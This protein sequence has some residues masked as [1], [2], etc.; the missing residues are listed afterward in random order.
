[1]QIFRIMNNPEITIRKIR[2]RS[3]INDSLFLDTYSKLMLGDKDISE[4]NKKSILKTAIFFLN[5]KDLNVE[6]LGYRIILRYSILFKDYR[7]IYDI[8]LSRDYIPITKLIERNSDI[9]FDLSSFSKLYI[10][11]YQDLFKIE[12]DGEFIYRSAGQIILNNYSYTKD[13]IAII[14]PTSYGKS[15]MIF[16]KINSN[17]NKKI[18]IIVPSKALL[19]QTKKALLKK[20]YIKDNFKKIITHPDMYKSG[21]DN[22]LAVLTQ[23][24]LLR[25]LQKNE[26]LV[27][28]LLLVDEA[29]N[30][31][32][33]DERAHLLAQVILILKKR[34]EELLINFYTPFL[35]D[36]KNLNIINSG[37]DL[38]S[39]P[40][41]EY[42]K[43]EKFYYYNFDNSDY[44]LYDQFLNQTFKIKS[45]TNYEKDISFVFS[46]S[47]I[48]NIV[49]L[50]RPKSVERFSLDATKMM[51]DIDL[52]PE[53]EKIIK[54]ISDFI[55][56]D[57]N[58]ITCLR[59]GILYHHGGIPDIVRLYIEDIYTK[60]DTFKFIVTTSTLLEGVNIPA[61][62]I[63]ILTP[64]KGHGHLTSSQFK[65]LI[66]RACRFREVFDPDN[67]KLEM[68]EPQ[69]FLLNG[70]YSPKDFNPIS[71]YEKKVNC[72]INIKDKVEN[73][74]LENS[75]NKETLTEKLEYLE[76]MESGS[77]GLN[78]FRSPYSDIGKYCYSNNINDFDI[79]SN[80]E[81]LVSNLKDYNEV[82]L[83]P[84]DNSD[85]LINAIVKIFF[86]NVELK[87]KRDNIKRL[88]NNEEARKFYSMFVGWRSKGTPYSVMINNFL[89]Y[90]ESRLLQGDTLIYLGPKW[91]EEKRNGY[92]DL[93]VNMRSKNKVQRINL[94]IAKIKEE[95]EFI[96]FNILKYLEV[97]KDLDLVNSDFYD[98][99]KYGTKN[100][101]VICML[102]NGLSMEL[103][104]LLKEKYLDFL[105]IDLDNDI[106]SYKLGLVKS[107]K[108]NNENGVLIFEAES[109]M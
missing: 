49:Y 36:S 75:T 74:L 92:Q 44:G 77:S 88:K 53:I 107:M 57:Y 59:S 103:A 63:F 70:S 12:G 56:P 61:E 46:N 50:N 21:Q 65:N 62:K 11:S 104:K 10:N 102:K 95:Q 26:S 2:H 78:D 87:D 86:S 22:L 82:V 41:S 67:G 79:I 84:I 96:D 25:L 28:D 94:A 100:K 27:I 31:L 24:R 76:N 23:E 17:L 37:I 32:D 6:K 69:I 39:Y 83:E 48:K 98:Q 108:D 13:N 106:I 85:L 43:I 5:S 4:S 55:H 16:K 1:M 73:P 47:S 60:Y 18:C 30:L 68:L 99:V 64:Q 101:I 9:S 7:P 81:Q 91:G 54:S 35:S 15:E 90:W 14:A 105:E 38:N 93:Y 71:F 20:D 8:A 19:A 40:L 34:N 89:S 80:E 33:D 66:G 97:I 29:H 52:S 109:N 72:E 51:P 45:S 58:L 42:M 3:N